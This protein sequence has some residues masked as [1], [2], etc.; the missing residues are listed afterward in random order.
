MARIRYRSTVDG[1]ARLKDKMSRSDA[2]WEALIVVVVLGFF[3]ES[4]GAGFSLSAIAGLRGS[5]GTR[6]T[7]VEAAATIR[8]ATQAPTPI[9]FLTPTAPPTPS[10]I[11]TS[12]PV[13]A[14]VDAIMTAHAQRPE[15]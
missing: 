7:A 15:T 12:V 5:L 8:T 13:L 3:V 4:L 14:T 10:P 11:E 2:I 6:P 1:L 9:L